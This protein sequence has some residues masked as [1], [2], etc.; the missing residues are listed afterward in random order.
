[1]L[2]ATFDAG[3]SATTF[4]YVESRDGYFGA[5]SFEWQRHPV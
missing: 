1:M 4:A 3:A 2:Q 5:K